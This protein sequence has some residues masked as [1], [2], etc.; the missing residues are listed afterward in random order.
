MG[1]LGVYSPTD[2][3]ARN[4]MAKQGKLG[5][6]FGKELIKSPSM[7]AGQCPVMNYN[8]DLM[9]AI[10]WGRMDYLSEVTNVEFIPLEK[11]PEAYH[12]FDEGAPKKFVIDPHGSVR[13]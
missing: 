11:A 5:V 3:G 8:R 9:M 1:V 12:I 4:E 13:K 10:L 6:D 2:P 7:T